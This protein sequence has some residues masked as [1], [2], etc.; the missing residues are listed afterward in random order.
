MH[1]STF[2]YH[3]PTE[4]QINSMEESRT[5]FAELCLTLERVLPH[6]SDRTYVLRKV[7]EAAMWANVSITREHDG[8]PRT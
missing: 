2:A 7:R 4:A 1:D 6:G 8:S 5:A 3:K